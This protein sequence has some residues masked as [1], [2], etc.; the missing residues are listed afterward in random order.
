[1]H[2]RDLGNLCSSAACNQGQLTLIYTISCGLQL[3]YYGRHTT[4]YWKKQTRTLRISENINLTNDD[5]MKYVIEPSSE[6]SPGPLP[7]NPA[8]CSFHGKIIKWWNQWEW[9]HY[10]GKKL[11]KL[12][13]TFS[14]GKAETSP[15]LD[16]GIIIHWSLVVR[17]YSDI[18]I[19]STLICVQLH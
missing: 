8:L 19:R 7:F 18:L 4:D 12:W 2:L 15:L 17:Y 16:R 14:N 13:K 5:V 10:S 1:M 9:L 3:N 11:T 6:N